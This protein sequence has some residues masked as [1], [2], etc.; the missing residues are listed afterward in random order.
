MYPGPFGIHLDVVTDDKKT[1][2]WNGSYF[3]GVVHS[4]TAG[5]VSCDSSEVEVFLCTI[6]CFYRNVSANT[7]LG[8]SIDTLACDEL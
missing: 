5:G 1:L 7:V 4:C 6:P 3:R 2:A 8:S